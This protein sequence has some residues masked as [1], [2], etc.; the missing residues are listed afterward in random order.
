MSGATQGSGSS[1]E[2]LSATAL[3]RFSVDIV[4]TDWRPAEPGK[5]A[6]PADLIIG[7]HLDA[8]GHG[9]VLC[10]QRQA[11]PKVMARFRLTE[12]ALSRWLKAGL[13]G[14]G[15]AGVTRPLA[16][17]IPNP[18]EPFALEV[19]DFSSIAARLDEALAEHAEP[20]EEAVAWRQTDVDADWFEDGL[21]ITAGESV[22][23][24]EADATP[25]SD[26]ESDPDLLSGTGFAASPV[27]RLD[28]VGDSDSV[29][30]DEVEALEHERESTRRQPRRFGPVALLLLVLLAAAGAAF[31][32][33]AGDWW[34]VA[35][36]QQTSIQVPGSHQSPPDVRPA[37][38]FD[39]LQAVEPLPLV[40]G[41]TRDEPLASVVEQTSVAT[42]AMA[43]AV[44]AP[45]AEPIVLIDTRLRIQGSHPGE[46]DELLRILGDG[47]F[48]GRV[49]TLLL[50]DPPRAVIDII[51]AE[52][53]TALSPTSNHPDVLRVRIGRHSDRIRV[54]L[55][56][57]ERR[58]IRFDV[59]DRQLIIH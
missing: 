41:P 55:D 15:T 9:I 8:E 47:S 43:P 14:I 28:I 5:F 40:E 7:F 26:D 53:A 54:V 11:E 13:L 19:G 51:G 31:L 30:P 4:A 2:D 56:L 38:L 12:P 34:P 42:P 59:A 58:P 48:G 45:V 35:A 39:E 21:A 22:V 37:R 10:Q 16:D 6:K 32:W 27:G 57:R 49:R 46:G 52:L 20:V 25:R 1:G 24:L 50:D 33:F 44:P 17:A 3:R 18:A 23:K 36:L 29:M